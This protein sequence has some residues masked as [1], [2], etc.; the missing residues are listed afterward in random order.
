MNLQEGILN[1]HFA[2][3]PPMLQVF[4]VKDGAMAFGGCSY[5]ERIVP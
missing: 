2:E 1:L 5:D 4:G 3:L